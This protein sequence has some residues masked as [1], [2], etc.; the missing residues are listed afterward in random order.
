MDMLAIMVDAEPMGHL[1]VNGRAPSERQLSSVFGCSEKDTRGYIKEME[2]AGV[3]SRTDTGVIFNR[4]MVRDKA[5]SDKAVQDGKRG[6]NPSI[7]G[8]K[9][10]QV[11]G[12]GNHGGL[13]PTDNRPSY[14]LEA[15]AE[16]EAEAKEIT[17]LRS[18]A[19]APG[20]RILKHTAIRDAVGRLRALTGQ[21]ERETRSAV[22]AMMKSLDD[23]YGT[24]LELFSAMDSAQPADP[25]SWLFGAL[26]QRRIAGGDDLDQFLNSFG[27]GS[28]ILNG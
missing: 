3:F 13:T 18:G 25:V 19:E 14:A 1:L 20:S 2:D 11:N 24:L 15:E 8:K 28:I 4:R 5:I 26:R 12:G 17:S 10:P 6:G 21:T 22:G 9:T 23:D 27:V 16:A 7:T